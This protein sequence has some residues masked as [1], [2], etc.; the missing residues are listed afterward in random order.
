MDDTTNLRQDDEALDS[1]G[2]KSDGTDELDERGDCENLSNS[3]R[4]GGGQ[5]SAGR[6][7]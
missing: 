4:Q 2:R 7:A 3:T 5:I 6:D 1:A